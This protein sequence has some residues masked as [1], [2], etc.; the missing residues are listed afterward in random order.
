MNKFTYFFLIFYT[1]TIF[2]CPYFIPTRAL[3]NG[4]KRVDNDNW[5]GF[6]EI[7]QSRLNESTIIKF[8][9]HIK[10]PVN[11]EKLSLKWPID[12]KKSSLLTRFGTPTVITTEQRMFNKNFYYSHEALD[13]TRH[14]HAESH[15]V[16]SPVSGIAIIIE[17]GIINE[18]LKDLDY[19]STAVAI[20]DENSNAIIS[21]LHIKPSLSLSKKYFTK[22]SKGDLLG[23]MALVTSMQDPIKQELYK[24]IHLTM[25]DPINKNLINPIFY[26]DHY[27]DDVK[28]I[29]KDISLFDK[30]GKKH[31]ALVH[32]EVDLVITGY[33]KDNFSNRNFEIAE[34]T[35]I[36]KDLHNNIIHQ[37]KDCH[38]DFLSNA[39]TFKNNKDAYY[40]DHI[41]KFVND[42]FDLFYTNAS[43]RDREF[44]YVLS[45]FKNSSH[46]CILK[47]DKDSNLSINKDIDFIN[48]EI[49]IKDYFGNKSRYVKEFK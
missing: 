7:G 26:T 39:L 1:N 41:G 9:K 25:I 47:K 28:P 5:A 42:D 16:Y 8:Q 46:R 48:V 29:I 17:D 11:V 14:D 34:F 36:V 32:G 20:L 6:N 21:L 13:I 18:S 10:N 4:L 45:H 27:I 3:L 40:L 38:L 33:D 22:V 31:D 12:S 37:V 30:K 19:Y 15:N 35:F 2:S 43:V 23:E 44:S 24:H 49:E